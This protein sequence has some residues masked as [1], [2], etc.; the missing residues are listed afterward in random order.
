[1]PFKPLPE[2]TVRTDLVSGIDIGAASLKQAGISLPPHMQGRDMFAPDYDRDYMEVLK[3]LHEEGELNEVQSHF[4]SDERPAE[5]LYDLKSD[6]HETN[7][8]VHSSSRSHQMALGRLR[9]ILHR[10][11]VETGDQ[12][13]FPETDAALEAVL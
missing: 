11:L 7:N 1:M 12:G 4:V 13:R 8:L 3:R 5:E 2:D 9:T 10:W 6:P